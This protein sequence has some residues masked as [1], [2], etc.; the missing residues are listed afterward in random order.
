MFQ[1]AFAT[2]P[3]FSVA[4]IAAALPTNLMPMPAPALAAFTT[5]VTV[6]VCVSD[7]LVPVI[8]SVR[9]PPG[10]FA[11]VATFSVA[12]PEPVTEGGV[13]EPVAFA[14]KPLTARLTV[15]A[16]PFSAPMS[17]T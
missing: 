11:A 16:K 14:G 17:I 6:A 12:L 10:E 15:P 9:L 2:T 1:F 8:E 3:A 4:P 13:N 5:T 7:P